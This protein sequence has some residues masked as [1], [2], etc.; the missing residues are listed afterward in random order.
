M[1]RSTW[2]TFAVYV[3][4]LPLLLSLHGLGLRQATAGDAQPAAA[5]AFVFLTERVSVASGGA[6]SAHETNGEPVLS[7]DG[8]YV[9]FDS[10]ASDLV[11]NDTNDEYDVFVH[12]RQTG[13]TERVSLAEDGD[14]GFRISWGPT[15]SADGRTVAFTSNA[16]L[17]GGLY[18][19]SWHI[20]VRDRQT[21]QTTRATV[22]SDGTVGNGSSVEQPA[23]SADGRYVAYASEATNLVIDDT[24]NAAD[25]FVHDRQTGQTTRVSLA[26][27]GAQANGYSSSAALSADGR[28]VAFS[29]D[30]PDLVAGDTNNMG[31]VFRHDRQ[32][33]ETILISR[34]LD[35]LSASDGA[36]IPAISADGTK[37]AFTSRSSDFVAGDTAD[38][39]VF[40]A[41]LTTGVIS[42][43]SVNSN[44]EKG[45]SQSEKFAMSADG[46]YVAFES[47]AS[48]LTPD[49]ANDHGDVFVRDVVAGET[50][51]A[52]LGADGQQ[53]NGASSTPGISPDGHTVGFVSGATNLVP[54]DTNDEDDIFVRTAAGGDIVVYLPMVQGSV[55]Q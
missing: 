21:N 26:T 5:V 44:G 9:V 38:A 28:Y 10:L 19:D 22:A 51:L 11:P 43:V 33:G 24:N 2:R 8:R 32:T 29:S 16:G 35:G 48:N 12:D 42:L 47:W 54:N 3:L 37:V 6:Q 27:G 20:Y 49:D 41:D 17:V 36:H 23:I 14:Q 25:I 13:T 55:T 30:A 34:R 1:S 45:N 46:R 31:D 18:S 15:I 39:D 53:G 50:W 40:L 7:Q 4:V 52:S